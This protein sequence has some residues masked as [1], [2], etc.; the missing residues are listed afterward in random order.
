MSF[1]AKPKGEVAESKNKEHKPLRLGKRSEQT[2]GEG[3]G[4]R[5]MNKLSKFW[6]KPCFPL[7]Y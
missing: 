7:L 4:G 6:D 5:T 3:P 2:M 1:C